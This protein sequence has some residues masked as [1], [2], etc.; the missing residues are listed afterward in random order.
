MK[1]IIVEGT[2]EEVAAFEELTGKISTPEEQPV[3]GPSTE[4]GVDSLILQFLASRTGGGKRLEVAEYFVRSAVERGDVAVVPGTSKHSADGLGNY[5]RL[6]R[7][8]PRN[9]GAAVY[10]TPSSGTVDP[11]LPK[12]AAAG[13]DGVEVRYPDRDDEYNVR[14]RIDSEETADLALE[15]LDEAVRRIS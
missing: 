3:T 14:I 8:G 12:E 9:V 6:Y 13:R 5:L 10:Y 1:L 4:N 2:P 7:K 15:L 11:R